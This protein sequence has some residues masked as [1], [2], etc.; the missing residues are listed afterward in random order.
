M[1]KGSKPLV[2]VVVPAYNHEKFIDEALDS[3]RQQTY[4]Y[5]EVIVMDDCSKDSTLQRAHVW[6]QSKVIRKRFPCVSVER[7]TENLNAYATINRGLAMA[8]G[9]WLTIL[10]SDDRY[11]PARIQRLVDHARETSS[12]LLFTGVRVIDEKGNRCLNSKLAAEIESA[13]DF[14]DAYPSLS[15]ALFKKNIAISTGN[16]FFSRHLYKKLGDFR[17]MKYCHDWDFVLRAVL[18]TEP[19]M[20]SEPL[21]D[22]RIHGNNSFANLKFEQYLE[23]QACY[24]AYFM[25]CLAGN[26]INPHTLSH[27]NWPL[28]FD[29]FVAEDGTLAGANYLVGESHIKYDYMGA[30]IRSWLHS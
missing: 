18:L 19:A 5:I 11:Y 13:T 6:Q 14:R 2:T 1:P 17:P 22:Y 24:R 26:C 29:K 16:L 27:K 28:L 7:N 23:S 30:Q 20:I 10:N 3:I 9:D 15:F 12:D 4:P 8:K 25:S 21:Y